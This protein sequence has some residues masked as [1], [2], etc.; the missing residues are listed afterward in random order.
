[1]SRTSVDL[2]PPLAP[3]MEM[4]RSVS[5]KLVGARIGT[6]ESNATTAAS[7]NSIMPSRLGGHST[8]SL[9]GRD[10]EG[11]C[12]HQLGESAVDHSRRPGSYDN[13]DDVAG[14]E[15]HYAYRERVGA[16]LREIEPRITAGRRAH[17]RQA[18]ARSEPR[19]SHYINHRQ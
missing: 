10:H 19:N 11:T 12:R 5:V 8:I 3:T 14:E 1:M 4:W 6:P 18:G 16:T 15:R 17:D 9:H 7:L 13:L 2:P